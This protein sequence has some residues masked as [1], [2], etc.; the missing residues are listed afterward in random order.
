MVP[1][2]KPTPYR[3][4]LWVPLGILQKY[5][6]TSDLGSESVQRSNCSSNY[7]NGKGQKTRSNIHR[8]IGLVNSS[9]HFQMNRTVL[10]F[11]IFGI[12]EMSQ[13]LRY[14]LNIFRWA[15]NLL[16]DHFFE[17]LRSSNIMI[18]RKIPTPSRDPFWIPF[19][20]LQ[21]Y[22][23]TSDLGSESVQ[24][25]ICSSNYKNGKGQKLRSNIH[26]HSGLV[27]SSFH[28]PMNRTILI[29]MI[30][31]IMEMS[32][33]PPMILQPGRCFFLLK[34]HFPISERFKSK[35]TNTMVES[36]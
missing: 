16:E 23:T 13:S 36:Q 32:Q 8:H 2:K 1:F 4:P 5:G 20:I 28:F 31:G 18:P 19:G 21:K 14:F 3:D 7:K 35:R 12:M 22:G 25:S 27:N 26:L 11:M 15:W 30:L 34:K 29:F 10:I 24:R 17:S 6:T 33:R 9:F